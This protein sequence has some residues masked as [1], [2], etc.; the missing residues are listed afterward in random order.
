[1]PVLPAGVCVWRPPPSEDTQVGR[2]V[3][4][5]LTSVLIA[6]PDGACLPFTVSYREDKGNIVVAARDIKPFETIIIDSPAIVGKDLLS[7]GL[8]KSSTT[9][10]V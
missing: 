2:E 9:R 3:P 5:S 4:N 1:M 7:L 6:R 8:I 10:T